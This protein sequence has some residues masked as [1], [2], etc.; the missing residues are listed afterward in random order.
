[1]NHDSEPKLE[2]WNGQFFER[3]F[4]LK[5]FILAS[6]GIVE[7]KQSEEWRGIKRN[8]ENQTTMQVFDPYAILVLNTDFLTTFL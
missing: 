8:A 6:F 7:G 3:N 5:G 4:N 1:M 2:I